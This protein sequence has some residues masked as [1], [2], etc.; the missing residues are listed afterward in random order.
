ML[1]GW[2]IPSPENKQT[3]IFA[4]GYGENRLH[5]EVPLL[6]LAQI[7]VNRG[8]NVLMFDFRN[9]GESEG[10]LTSGGQYEVQDLLGAVDFIKTRPDI[11]QKITLFGFSM[12]A[13]ISIIAGAR[14]PAVSGV[15]ADSPFADLN[16]YLSNRLSNWTNLPNVPFN[17][18]VLAV[19][20][21]LTGVNV[22]EV[23]PLKEIK[24]LGNRPLLIIQGEADEDVSKIN[25]ELLKRE[26]P[27]AQ[28]LKIPGATHV[29]SF[30]TDNKD[31]LTEV[32]RFLEKP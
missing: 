20:P 21:L 26:Y 5:D 9:S 3:I 1:K 30:Q 2:F 22:K 15:I 29:K 25:G 16:R 23:S 4:H 13:S 27:S 11:N 8:F 14:E 10:N 7:L 18:T 12:G 31:Y 24:K 32:F 19:T 28:L 17:R 6:Q